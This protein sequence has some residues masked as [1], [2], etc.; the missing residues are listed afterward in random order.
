L[1]EAVAL[2]NF[3][4]FGSIN[5]LNLFRGASPVGGIHSLERFRDIIDRERA[6]TDR[7]GICFSLVVFRLKGRKRE[8]YRILYHLLHLVVS[9]VRSSD[10]VGWVE[11][12]APGVLLAGA[13]DAGARKFVSMIL[14]SLPQDLTAPVFDVYVYPASG[15]L[16]A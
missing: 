11:K 16:W 5:P 9:R 1:G 10:E 3:S 7:T 13:G 15:I 14:S 12:S 6:R 2:D 4:I 8:T